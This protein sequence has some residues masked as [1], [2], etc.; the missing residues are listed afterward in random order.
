[1][2]KSL[3]TGICKNVNIVRICTAGDQCKNSDV[4]NES[5]RNKK[6]SVATCTCMHVVLSKRDRSSTKENRKQYY[7]S[8][9]VPLVVNIVIFLIVLICSEKEVSKYLF[10]YSPLFFVIYD[11]CVFWHVPHV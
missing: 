2:D 4:Y 8:T 5:E 7:Y 11:N 9:F 3:S 1:M 6:L 10:F